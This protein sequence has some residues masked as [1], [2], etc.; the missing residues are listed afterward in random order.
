MATA[1]E[2]NGAGDAG[3]CVFGLEK[4]ETRVLILAFILNTAR[5]T[6]GSATCFAAFQKRVRRISWFDANV[7][8]A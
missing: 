7:Q 6:T 8:Q 2:R 5:M 1:F 3:S 4:N